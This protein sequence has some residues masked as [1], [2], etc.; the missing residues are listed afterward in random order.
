MSKKGSI[1]SVKTRKGQTGTGRVV[2]SKPGWFDSPT[3]DGGR[4]TTIEK[5]GV[6]VTGREQRD[7]GKKS[8]KARNEYFALLFVGRPARLCARRVC[9]RNGV[10]ASRSAGK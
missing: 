5:E 8:G 4:N 1:A 3:S 6:R 2:E 9:P 7:E 10:I